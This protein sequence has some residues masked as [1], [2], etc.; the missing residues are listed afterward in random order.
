MESTAQRMTIAATPERCFAVVTDFERYPEWVAD[1]KEVHVLEHD[2]QG[3]GTVVSFRAGAFGRSTNYVLAYDF[4]G[5][6]N[7]ISWAQQ[8][9]DLTSRL[10]GSYE[11]RPTD[12]GATE[13]RYEL[14]VEL[15]VPIPGFVKRRVEANILHAA[16]RDLKTRVEAER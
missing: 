13:V 2:A 5:A 4:S 7:A 6:P 12:D 9:G 11:F 14:A 16:V 1:V 15:R 10:D 3:R 8:D